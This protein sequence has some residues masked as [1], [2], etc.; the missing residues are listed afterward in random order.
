MMPKRRGFVMRGTTKWWSPYDIDVQN[1][2][3]VLVTK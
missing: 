3:G 2:Y 1:K